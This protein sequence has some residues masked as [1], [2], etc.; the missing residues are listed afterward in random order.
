MGIAPGASAYRRFAEITKGR[1]H[2]RSSREGVSAAVS[3]SSPRREEDLLRPPGA[4][5]V[6]PR[7]R[8]DARPRFSRSTSIA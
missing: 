7:R 6:K 2:R 8:T 5:S 1:T 3:Q 4:G